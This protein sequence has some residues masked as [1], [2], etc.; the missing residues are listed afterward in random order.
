MFITQN[1]L[2]FVI[3]HLVSNLGRTGKIRLP[4]EESCVT[5]YPDEAAC[6]LCKAALCE[7]L[8]AIPSE[9]CV[10]G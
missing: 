9:G 1:H 3:S 4:K 8:I 7:A 6:A 2:S 5:K 10:G